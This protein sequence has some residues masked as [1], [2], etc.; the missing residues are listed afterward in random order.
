MLKKSRQVKAVQGRGHLFSEDLAVRL[1]DEFW[2]G[3]S[4]ANLRNFLQFF[5]VFYKRISR[6]RYP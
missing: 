3:F 6:P 1:T 5:L 4:F 2:R